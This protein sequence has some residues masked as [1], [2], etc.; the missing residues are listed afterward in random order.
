MWQGVYLTPDDFWRGHVDP[1]ATSSNP[2][3]SSMVMP[4]PSFEGSTVTGDG[5]RI[6]RW[7]TYQQQSTPI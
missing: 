3:W 6:K 7:S 1:T 4:R 2:L 5:G